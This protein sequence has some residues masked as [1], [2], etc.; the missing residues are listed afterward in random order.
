MKTALVVAL[1][2]LVSTLA[3]AQANPNSNAGE[4]TPPPS[5][6]AATEGADNR[7]ITGARNLGLGSDPEKG[8]QFN[9]A[10]T[11]GETATSDARLISGAADWTSITSVIGTASL[12]RTSRVATTDLT[13]HGAAN[14]Y[15]AD[16]RYNSQVHQFGVAQTMNVGRWTILLADSLDY[17]PDSSAGLPIYG[18]YGDNGV[19]LRQTYIPDGSI[20]TPF[21]TRL[22]NTG[23]AELQYAFTR[24]TSFTATGSYGFTKFPDSNVSLDVSLLETR[25]RSLSAGWNHMFG[26]SM[27]GL[28]YTNTS[29]Q[30]QNLQQTMMTHDAELSYA[31]RVTRRVSFHVGGGPE[32]LVTKVGGVEKTEY[33]P[34]GHLA[35]RRTGGRTSEALEYTHGVTSGSGVTPGAKSDQVLGNISHMFGRHTGIFAGAGYARNTSILLGDTYNTT[36][37]IGG[38]SRRLGR[39]ASLGLMYEYKRQM[40]DAALFSHLQSHSIMLTF[41]WA[42]DPIQLR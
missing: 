5:V 31:Y 1:A 20:L 3:L 35:L 7:P 36:T 38:A 41:T 42:F 28:G 13:Y 4:T 32:I 6:R 17:A 12:T 18:L 10:M 34:F 16:S 27:I 11:F 9:A 23:V 21:T 22:T 39:N 37:A 30:F 29:F 24:K 25:Q 19:D 15:A 40:T 33:L 2:V 8:N 26:R 14:I